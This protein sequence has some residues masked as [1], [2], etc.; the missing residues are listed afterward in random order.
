MQRFVV[1]RDR[2]ASPQHVENGQRINPER[3]AIAANAKV[4]MKKRPTPQE[5][6]QPQAPA[7][8]PSRGFK[9][10][11]DSTAA[12]QHAPQRRYSDQHQKHDLYDTDA[13][14][15]DTTVNQS[16]I[17]GE[18]SQ[19]RDL[20]YQ[21]QGGVVDLGSAGLD[22]DE[23]EEEED[24]DEDGEDDDADDYPFT[25]EDVEYLQAQGQTHLTRDDAA[26]FL[27]RNRP[28]GFPTID[29][30][31]YPS[32]TEGNPTEYDGG[33]LPTSEDQGDGGLVSPSP[34]RTG[35]NG[36]RPLAPPPPPMHRG[37]FNEGTGQVMHGS[38]KMFQQSA[39]IR[40]QQRINA[41]SGQQSGHGYQP[42]TAPVQSSQPPSYSQAYRELAP[43]QASNPNTRSDHRVAFGQLQQPVL[44]QPPGHFQATT[45]PN[46]LVEVP[47]TAR[48]P[49]SGRNK[50]VP[51][52][53]YQ[54]VEPAQLHGA[55][56]RPDGDYDP[57]TLDTMDYKQLKSESFDTN[58]RA[59]AH[60]LSKDMLQKPLI[61]RL[62]YVQQNL[63]A[64]KQSEFFH[65]LPTTEWEDA[66]DWF[67]DQFSSIIQRTKQARQKK[68]K[69]AQ[70]FEDEIE[71]RHKH[72]SKKQR[73]VEDAMHKMQ[74]QG[75]GL[76][77]KS[78]RASKSPKPRKR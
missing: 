61:E 31:S 58:P 40:D 36:Q 63:D 42:H 54:L 33:Q 30:D 70:D 43:T 74:A 65:A 39:H 75:E 25:Q 4:T 64:G 68:R 16:V 17:Q 15:I 10:A 71:K 19:V 35:M 46:R 41:H 53:Q 38:N 51:D 13:E 14:S 50:V 2:A 47:I 60:P 62:V 9:H 1:G 7:G 55:V 76:V 32:T 59:P 78:P 11:Q 34:R 48:N 56:V 57:D 22:G 28:E 44:R 37:L 27:R 21:Q 66:G 52:I 29:G 6:H 67:L 18:D 3:Q 77:P 45:Q 49:S 20:Q 72:V 69:L 24:D 12:N 23:D 8:I 26:E 73:Q 5:A